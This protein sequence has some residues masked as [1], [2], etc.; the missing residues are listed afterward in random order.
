MSTTGIAATKAAA[1]AAAAGAEAAAAAAVVAAASVNGTV[2]V[3]RSMCQTW[4]PR[5]RLVNYTPDQ[6]ECH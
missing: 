6:V 3:A 1:G 5:S 2:A 4:G